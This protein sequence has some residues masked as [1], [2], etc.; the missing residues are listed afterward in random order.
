MILT[1]AV[2][3]I[4]ANIDEKNIQFLQ[5]SAATDLRWGGNVDFIPAFLQFIW[6]CSSESIIKIGQHLGEKLW[7]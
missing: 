6:E 2:Y 5:G 7:K 4:L 3:I 1:F